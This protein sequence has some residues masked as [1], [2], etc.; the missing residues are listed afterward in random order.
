LFLYSLR[1]ALL[2]GQPRLVPYF[3]IPELQWIC[4]QLRSWLMRGVLAFPAVLSGMVALVVM[5][6]SMLCGWIGRRF[7]GWPL[8]TG[9]KCRQTKYSGEH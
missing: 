9:G 1:F 3:P 4:A 5:L 2:V 7:R 8:L 6:G